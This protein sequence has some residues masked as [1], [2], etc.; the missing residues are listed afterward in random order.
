M[1][2]LAGIG[3]VHEM[4][5]YV[6]QATRLSESLSYL[7]GIFS[8]K[9]LYGKNYE[10]V[11]VDQ[12][13]H[14][15]DIKGI[16]PEDES[17]ER[18][19]EL[20]IAIMNDIEMYGD[21]LCVENKRSLEKEYSCFEPVYQLVKYEFGKI[22]EEKLKEGQAL[23][24]REACISAISTYAGAVR[25]V[26]RDLGRSIFEDKR[27][28]KKIVNALSR[29]GV[30]VLKS[31]VLVS[32]SGTYEIIISAKVRKEVCISTKQVCDILGELVGRVLKPEST[33]RMVLT[34]EYTTLRFTQCPNFQILH[35]V[36]QRAKEGSVQSGDN[37]LAMDM[38]GGKK[39]V[40][41]SDGMGSGPSAYKIS[42]KILD[43]MEVLLQSGMSL[44]NT[45]NICNSM[46]VSS[47]KGM[48]FGTLDVCV[49]DTCSGMM[50]MSKAG[51]SYTFIIGPKEN[52]TV[53]PSSLPIG[54][55][56]G[57]ETDYFTEQIEDG[58]FVVM[59][60]DGVTELIPSENKSRFISDIIDRNE[61]RN[62]KEL[63]EVMMEEVLGRNQNIATDDMMI[64]VIAC[65]EA[66][67]Y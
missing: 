38:P 59:M 17:A 61:S 6:M 26:T 65:W 7:S 5:P 54:V 3:Q 60:T 47:Q 8:A 39:A 24:E 21:E 28:H 9:E 1:K 20:V 15:L 18:M 32:D 23:E 66:R 58:T 16:Q 64:A 42:G 12:I 52:T 48:D 41:I 13:I 62:P 35:G 34:K 67:L 27:I 43:G 49:M 45:I 63:A 30:K 51:G 2:K 55:V 33:Q 37:F 14:T 11:D 40:I 36:A 29:S 56:N 4:N 19:R 50:E 46:L 31:T 25:E 44:K 10:D 53:V 22:K 57:V